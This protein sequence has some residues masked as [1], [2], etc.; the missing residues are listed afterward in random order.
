MI[1]DSSANNTAPQKQLYQVLQQTA[2]D[3]D[4]Q[5]TSVFA[6]DH[7]YVLPGAGP[8]S[9]VPEGMGSVLSKSVGGGDAASKAR[10]RKNEEEDNADDL[11]KKFKF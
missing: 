9:N 1:G 11:G 6:S 3:A 10:K 2:V 8:G 7:A 5:A 4:S